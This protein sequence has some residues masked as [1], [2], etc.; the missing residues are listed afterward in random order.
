MKLRPKQIQSE[1]VDGSKSATNLEEPKENSSFESNKQENEN[2]QTGR[3]NLE[4]STISQ[5]SLFTAQSSHKDDQDKDVTKPEQVEEQTEE[6]KPEFISEVIKEEE[7]AVS[8]EVYEPTVVNPSSSKTSE[9]THIP[10]K[11][12]FK[13]EFVSCS[14]Q[15]ILIPPSSIQQ[16][17]G[18][19]LQPEIVKPEGWLGFRVSACGTHKG[20]RPPVP[21][22]NFFIERGH[23]G[24]DA[25]FWSENLAGDAIGIADGAT[26]N[27]QLGYDPGD[28]SR[29]LMKYCAEIFTRESDCVFD[30]KALLVKAFDDVQEKTTVYGR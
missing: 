23:F 20:G 12:G 16:S 15:R 26:G 8:K 30:A 4:R 21:K 19:L 5:S 18:M 24:D 1:A 25:G 13:N 17:A 7:E 28:F 3:Q 14:K 10:N 27:R 9:S 6:L 2:K 11:A 29:E 22:S